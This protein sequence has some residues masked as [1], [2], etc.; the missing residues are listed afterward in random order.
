M[1]L[2]SG[3]YPKVSVDGNEIAGV[4]DIQVHQ[5]GNDIVQV[6]MTCIAGTVKGEGT[7]RVE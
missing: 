2:T 4:T 1:D 7:G 6:E 5:R 3:Q